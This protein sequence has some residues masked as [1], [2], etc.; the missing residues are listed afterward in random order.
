LGGCFLLAVFLIIEVAQILGSIFSMR[1]ARYVLIL[2]KNGL[3]YI[4]GDFFTNSSGR[5]V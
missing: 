1:Q 4:F 3:G 2:A 5:P